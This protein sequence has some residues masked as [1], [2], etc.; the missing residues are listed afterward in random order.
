MLELWGSFLPCK[1]CLLIITI[2]F[3]KPEWSM[4]SSKVCFTQAFLF[5]QY[6]KLHN[7]SV[8]RRGNSKDKRKKAFI[9]VLH[10]LMKA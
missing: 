10:K 4:Y 5:V 6:V 1:K 9:I 3:G 7:L 2:I 8:R